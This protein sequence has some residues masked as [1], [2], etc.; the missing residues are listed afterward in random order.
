MLR[1]RRNAH[2]KYLHFQF[3]YLENSHELK[4]G[5]T[6]TDITQTYYVLQTHLLM[7]ATSRDECRDSRSDHLNLELSEAIR[8]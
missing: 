5:G 4:I 2:Q 3:S 8:Q 6:I 7:S 1:K